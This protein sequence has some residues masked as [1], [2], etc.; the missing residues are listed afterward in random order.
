MKKFLCYLSVFLL[1][2]GLTGT[3]N[4]FNLIPDELAVDFRDD[5]W[6]AIEG[7]NSYTIDGIT[8]AHGNANIAND[9]T[10]DSDG[11]GIDGFQGD[12]GE[13]ND[14][15]LLRVYFDGGMDLNGFWLTNLFDESTER[16]P[17]EIGYVE[18]N[19]TYTFGFSGIYADQ[20]F[21]EYFV[22]FGGILNVA[23]AEFWALNDTWGASPSDYSVAGAS[24][25]VP[26]P[27][28]IVLMGLGLVGLAGMGRKKLFKK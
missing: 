23:K 12:D 11:I 18:I 14:T 5:A 22:D 19:D 26:E 17:Y 13:I 2:I 6:E 7:R 28:T 1:I 3:A 16:L 20:E 8:V 4:A 9:L 10:H 27:G 21:G 25:P 15:E 24:A